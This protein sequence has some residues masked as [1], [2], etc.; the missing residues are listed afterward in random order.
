M[1]LAWPGPQLWVPLGSRSCW[2]LMGAQG[3]K[4]LCNSG[5]MSVNQSL[6]LATQPDSTYWSGSYN[7]QTQKV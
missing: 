2:A 3:V 7:I 1:D 4:P 6:G 5:H